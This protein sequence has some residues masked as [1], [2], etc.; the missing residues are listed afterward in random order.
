MTVA[1]SHSRVSL[2]F[3]T[4]ISRCRVGRAGPGQG[5]SHA[6]AVSQCEM[7]FVIVPTFDFFALLGFPFLRLSFE[8]EEGHDE[9]DRLVLAPVLSDCA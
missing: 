9:R 1:R 8:Q 2:A 5:A 7:R 4:Y 6:T 3:T